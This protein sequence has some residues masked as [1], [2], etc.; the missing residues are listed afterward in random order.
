MN[1]PDF[2]PKKVIKKSINLDFTFGCVSLHYSCVIYQFLLL[3]RV[4][5][6]WADLHIVFHAQPVTK[7][8]MSEKMLLR[9]EP[10]LVDG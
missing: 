4:S 2:N 9:L 5:L 7:K 6:Q 10:Q 3:P 1:D 8:K